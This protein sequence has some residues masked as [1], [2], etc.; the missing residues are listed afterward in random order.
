MYLAIVHI[1]KN[2]NNLSQARHVSFWLDL[3]FFLK[4]WHISPVNVLFSQL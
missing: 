3:V 4:K 2:N 1:E